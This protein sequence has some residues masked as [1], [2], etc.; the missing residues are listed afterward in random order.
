MTTLLLPK[1]SR[2]NA[3]LGQEL[4]KIFSFSVVRFTEFAVAFI[5]FVII[6]ST[7]MIAILGMS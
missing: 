1:L 6:I 2:V 4:M 7:V 3:L 5:V